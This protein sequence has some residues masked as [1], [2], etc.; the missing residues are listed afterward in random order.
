MRAKRRAKAGGDALSTPNR[1]SRPG[2]RTHCGTAIA[3]LSAA[4]LLLA[5][6]SVQLA[7]SYD[8]TILDGLTSANEQ[9][10]TLFA[11]VSSGTEGSPF[12]DRETTYNELIGKFGALRLQAL[13]RPT[14]QPLILDYLGLAPS[15]ATASEPENRLKAPTADIL[16]TIIDK[17]TRMRDKDKAGSLTK[18]FVELFE[19]SYELSITQA[20]AYEKALQ[21]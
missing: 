2:A 19:N 4:I 20:I 21:R 3:L 9:A 12:S 1:I 6:C 13:A 11:S 14:P 10:M 8:T 5:G 18:E 16:A 15:A 17:L 7:P